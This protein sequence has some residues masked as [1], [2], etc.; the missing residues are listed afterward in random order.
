[1]REATSKIEGMSIAAKNELL[2]QY[3]INFNNIPVWQKRGI[4][5]YWKDVKKEEF[6]LKNNEHLLVDRRTLHTDFELPMREEY[7]TFIYDLVNKYENE[8]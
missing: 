6:N 8:G 5:I 3:G 7:N 2:F 1:M 4:G